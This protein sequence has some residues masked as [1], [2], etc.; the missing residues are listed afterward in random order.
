M[1]V[2]A[3]FRAGHSQGETDQLRQMQHRHVQLPADIGL[4]LFLEAVEHG[5]TQRAGRHQSLRAVGLGGLD[6]LP[7]QL[8]RDPLVMRG[9][10]EAAAFGAAGIVDRLAAQLFRELFERAVVA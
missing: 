2:E 3:Q 9:G 7:G 10:M 6:V 8:D 4:D 5:V 1:L